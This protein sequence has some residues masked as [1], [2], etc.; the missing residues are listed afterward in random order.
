MLVATVVVAELFS[1]LC[2]VLANANQVE[3]WQRNQ[4]QI[5]GLVVDLAATAFA[6][7]HQQRR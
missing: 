3:D 2:Q 4:P 5:D 6:Q 1:K 7:R